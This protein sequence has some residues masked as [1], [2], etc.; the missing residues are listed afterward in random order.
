MVFSSSFFLLVFLPLFLSIYFILPYRFKNSWALIASIF[1]YAW[2]APKFIFVLL[3]SIGIDYWIV[4]WKFKGD[5]KKL[6][7]ALSIGL[8]ILLLGFFKYA[9]FFMENLNIILNELGVEKSEWME[10]A[11]PIGIS[12]FTFQ[13][14]SYLVDVYRGSSKALKLFDHTLYVILFPQLIAGPIVRFNEIARDI[15]DRQAK[16]NPNSRLLG[17]FRFSIG[18]GKKVIIANVLGSEADRIFELDANSLDSALSWYGALCY[19][20]QIYFD[21]SGYSD[22]AIGIGKMLGFQ[23]PEN[24]NNPYTS[25]SITEFWRRWHITLSNWM[26]DYLYIPLGGNR[27]SKERL[28]VNL[29]L[30]FL[31]SG[32]WHGAAWTFVVWGAY[33]GL[34]L[35]LERLFLN[36]V[37]ALLPNI[38]RMLITFFVVMIGWI[39]FNADSMEHSVMYIQKMLL[40]QFDFSV[41]ELEAGTALICA[42]LLSFYGAIPKVEQWQNRILN[43]NLNLKTSFLYTLMSLLLLLVSVSLIT[44]ADFNPFIYFK[45]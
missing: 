1:F 8:N 34:F 15:V 38:I 18:L 13:K 2:G 41:I 43:L 27:V 4:N 40:F 37:Y 10:I 9:N 25:K 3:L 31:I 33:H 32:L 7:F 45:F 42:A 29:W 44:S 19:T 11:L 16:I 36:K 28:Y 30:V 14:I 35:V 24:F 22:M 17:I 5:Q 6:W 39:F 21:F 20:F 26:K 12:F 23:F